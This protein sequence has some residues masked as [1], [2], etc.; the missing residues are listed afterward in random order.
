MRQHYYLINREVI[1]YM[2]QY[3]VRG[4]EQRDAKRLMEW[5]L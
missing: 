1:Q 3:E 2:V 5:L 4:P